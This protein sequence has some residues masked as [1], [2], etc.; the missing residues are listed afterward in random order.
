MDCALHWSIQKRSSRDIREYNTYTR[1]ALNTETR[2]EYE[3]TARV[4][5]LVKVVQEVQVV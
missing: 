4:L 3:T 5:E 1:T 2:E